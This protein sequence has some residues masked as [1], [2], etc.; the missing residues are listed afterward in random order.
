M[1]EKYGSFK[2]LSQNKKPM[3][4]KEAWAMLNELALMGQE[5]VPGAVSI[6]NVFEGKP[7]EAVEELQDWIPGNA[8]YQNFIRGKDQDWVRNAIDLATIGIPLAK[9]AGKAFKKG[10]EIVE[11]VPKGGKEGFV[12]NPKF[13]WNSL[14]PEQK[15]ATQQAMEEWTGRAQRHNAGRQTPPTFMV[16]LDDNLN[17]AVMNIAGDYKFTPKVA[18]KPNRDIKTQAILPEN[19]GEAAFLRHSPYMSNYEKVLNTE[20]VN[21][22]E[23][24]LMQAGLLPEYRP[25]FYGPESFAKTFPT[26][27]G[28]YAD[29]GNNSKAMI[30]DELDRKFPGYREV[31]KGHG[32][33]QSKYEKDRIYTSYLLDPTEEKIIQGKTDAILHDF[34]R[35]QL[36]EIYKQHK[37]FYEDEIANLQERLDY[38]KTEPTAEQERLAD[39]YKK[40]EHKQEFYIQ[41]RKALENAYNERIIDDL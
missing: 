4:A 11:K 9:P 17:D 6:R 32:P 21:D 19:T 29:I 20:R 1:A 27:E 18:G 10:A 2:D 14:T 8:A 22:E 33:G 5:F 25:D 38:I 30:I 16:F 28:P 13:D 3:S 36:D 41:A 26:K 37:D 12:R 39:L 40:L 35:D 23:T 24:R 31:M 15:K 7:R 34:P